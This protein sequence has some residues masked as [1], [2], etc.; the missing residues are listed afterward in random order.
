MT[1][2]HIFLA[3]WFVIQFNTM[4][5]TPGLGI[6]YAGPF[7]TQNQC[8]EERTVYMAQRAADKVPVSVQ[9]SGCVEGVGGKRP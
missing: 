9:V 5:P 6:V 3:W 8:R 1:K 2:T 4:P 7:K